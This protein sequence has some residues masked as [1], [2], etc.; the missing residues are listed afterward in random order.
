MRLTEISSS[1]RLIQSGC[2][3]KRQ[4]MILDPGKYGAGAD[5]LG[6]RSGKYNGRSSDVFVKLETGRSWPI[7]SECRFRRCS[8]DKLLLVSI[9]ENSWSIRVILRNFHGQP[10]KM[11]K[12]EML[13]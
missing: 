4:G 1:K 7:S 5:W 13:P 12:T 2:P 8:A 6:G 3:R 9:R 10:G 11:A